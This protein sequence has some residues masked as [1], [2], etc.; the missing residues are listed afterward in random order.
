L[1]LGREATALLLDL[2]DPTTAW[3]TADVRRAAIETVTRA[4]RLDL[5]DDLP[6]WIDDPDPETR[7]AVLRAF[8]RL[9][10]VPA[11]VEAAVLAATADAVPFVRTQAVGACVALPW[12]DV[13]APLWTAL[14]DPERW[15][16]R[17]AAETLAAFGA[18][19][20][21]VLRAAASRHLDR[22]ARDTAAEV[23]AWS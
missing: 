21:A 14:G 19:G 17:T 5:A 2:L 13:S 1:L 11:G 15:V 7:A 6:A 23:L 20:R 3:V 9:E 22:F 12:H 8:R 16:R 10:H 18:Q 4:G